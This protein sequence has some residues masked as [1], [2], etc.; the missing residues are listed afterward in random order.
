MRKLKRTNRISYSRRSKVTFAQ[1]GRRLKDNIV[2][3]WIDRFSI[4]LHIWAPLIFR[5]CRWSHCLFK[6]N[7][8]KGFISHILFYR[9][10]YWFDMYQSS[11]ISH[12]VS[13]C[14]TGHLSLRERKSDFCEKKTSSLWKAVLSIFLS[15]MWSLVYLS[16]CFY[17][18]WYT[19][20]LSQC[21]NLP[22]THAPST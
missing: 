3:W 12:I 2:R 21:P 11:R 20:S 10:T 1:R 17:L 18:Q 7:Q 5:L 6:T 16:E 15:P 14:P 9:D 8:V 19:M 4:N 22:N 13:S